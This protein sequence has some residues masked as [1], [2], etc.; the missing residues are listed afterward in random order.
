VARAR[1]AFGRIDIVVN[2]AGA[3]KRGEFVAL[4]DADWRD[5]FELKFFGAVRLTRAAW[6]ELKARRGVLINIAGVGGRTP[7]PQFTIGGSVNAAMLSF[8]KAMADVGLV[9][10]V[11]VA[12]INPGFIRTDRFKRRL[13]A[14]AREKGLDS[15]AAEALM[16][17]ENGVTRVGEP[18]DVA[19]LVAY[20][21]SPAGEY[22]HGSI[23]DIDGGQTKTF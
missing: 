20:L 6:P 3:T 9:D 14:F 15:T 8:T 13:E 4:S 10:H 17:K 23:I 16:V 11:R 2:N 22:L 21:V 5:G 12:A 19:Q 18:D 1:E 7:G